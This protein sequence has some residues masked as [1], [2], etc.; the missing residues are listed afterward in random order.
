MQQSFEWLAALRFPASS[1]MPYLISAVARPES[2]GVAR[3]NHEARFIFWT[4]RAI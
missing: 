2:K 4:G 1:C 3:K